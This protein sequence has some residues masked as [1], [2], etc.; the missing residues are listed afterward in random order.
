M[1]AQN[2]VVPQGGE[3]QI[4]RS[5]SDDADADTEDVSN[6]LRSASISKCPDDNN[7]D[8]FTDGVI[9]LRQVTATTTQQAQAPEIP[10]IMKKKKNKRK[11]KQK[12]NVTGGGGGSKKSA[13][14]PASGGRRRNNSHMS[15][16]SDSEEDDFDLILAEVKEDRIKQN[17][18]VVSEKE[19]PCPSPTSTARFNNNT[20]KAA[21]S[22]STPATRVPILRLA[23]SV[24]EVCTS[25]KQ[26][27]A[28]IMAAVAHHKRRQMNG[29][30]GVTF[31]TA[32]VWEMKR[33]FGMESVPADG[34]YP[35][36]LSNNCVGEFEYSLTSGERILD[37]NASSDSLDEGATAAV[38][39][40]ERCKKNKS[41]DRAPRQT[42]AQRKILLLPSMDPQYHVKELEQEKKVLQKQ[43][44]ESHS[45]RASARI[46]ATNK[47][48]HYHNA[49]LE[50]DCTLIRN[51]LEGLR[52][53]R[54]EVG[55][56]CHRETKFLDHFDPSNTNLN[57]NKIMSDRKLREEMRKRHLLT[58]EEKSCSKKLAADDKRDMMARLKV[59]MEQEPC[60]RPGECECAN[61]GIA[62]HAD[63]C[64]CCSGQKRSEAPC[65]ASCCGNAHGI[66]LVDV[67]GIRAN[68]DLVI[69]KQP[70][71]QEA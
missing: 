53:S 31:G 43:A 45:H 71:V 21:S 2:K 32:T 14:N 15:F 42:E 1:P 66:N 24:M 9:D 51:E 25:V 18:V 63:V 60:C 35:L 44:K 28:A 16:G 38:T 8:E 69:Q 58:T 54:S 7:D 19:P 33:C 3:S 36:G 61:A 68:R 65:T 10:G 4:F 11:G 56:S 29:S 34:G 23:P 62:C 47:A 5:A 46:D 59:A 49:E 17:S 20:S 41:V 12:K 40:P 48:S 50:H 57:L 64:G 22:M 55:C 39:I 52:L 70:L 67:I 13:V 6:R 37:A 26:K 30:A 27:R